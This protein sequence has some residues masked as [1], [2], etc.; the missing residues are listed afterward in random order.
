MVRGSTDEAKWSAKVKGRETRGGFSP[1]SPCN[2]FDPPIVVILS[3]IPSNPLLEKSSPPPNLTF[4]D[5][6]DSERSNELVYPLL[7]HS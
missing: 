5:E 1:H 2:G 6:N 4:I 3:I 7:L